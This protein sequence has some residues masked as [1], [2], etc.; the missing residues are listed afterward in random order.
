MPDGRTD[1]HRDGPMIR[2]GL[3]YAVSELAGL[4]AQPTHLSG[5]APIDSLTRGGLSPGV[6]W[7]VAGTPS[8]G[9]TALVTQLAATA[10]RTARVAVA[11]D[12]LATHLLRDQVSQAA[13]RSGTDRTAADRIEIASWV[14]IPDFRCDETSWFGADYD[15][16]VIDCFDEMLRPQA[17][18]QGDVVVRRARWLRELARRSNTALVL[19]AR[20]GRPRSGGWKAFERAW[21]R[22]C[23]RAVFDDIA[24][25]RLQLCYDKAGRV[26]FSGFARGYGQVRG[27][28]HRRR[29]SGLL[30]QAD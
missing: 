18:P 17:W 20:A 7:T 1:L 11:N 13:S 9:V 21:H 16:L 6:V 25:L 26:A 8:V 15:L 23:A 14:P 22:H 4:A 5:L 12:H 2:G 3:G 10:S 19:T 29:G 30:L 28:G 24:D 27:S